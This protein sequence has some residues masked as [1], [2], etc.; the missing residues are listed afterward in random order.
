MNFLRSGFKTYLNFQPFKCNIS[1]FD[2][3]HGNTVQSLYNTVFGVQQNGQFLREPYGPRRERPVFGVL[4][5]ARFKPV[6][7]AT[8]TS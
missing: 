4:H 2:N 1:R 6:C 3:A 5:K 7:S 8:E